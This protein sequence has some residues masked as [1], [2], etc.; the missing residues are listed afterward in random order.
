[1]RL[2]R[3]GMC[4]AVRRVVRW[5]RADVRRNPLRNRGEPMYGVRR[6]GHTR[7]EG[8]RRRPHFRRLRTAPYEPISL[9][10][11]NDVPRRGTLDEEEERDM[12][13]RHRTGERG[14]ALALVA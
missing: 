13:R 8:N 10:S 1:M 9:L 6:H 2:W 7:R 4:R 5:W 3:R 12:K 11:H 14:V